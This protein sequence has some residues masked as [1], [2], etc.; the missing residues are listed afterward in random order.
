MPA[1]SA[2]IGHASAH[3]DPPTPAPADARADYASRPIMAGVMTDQGETFQR[4]GVA[5]AAAVLGVL[6]DD[7]C[8]AVLTLLAAEAAE[9][10]PTA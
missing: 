2:P 3:P 5:E 6:P 4:V 7:D 10:A 8:Q 1:A 9:L